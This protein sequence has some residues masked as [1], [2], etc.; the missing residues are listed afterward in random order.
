MIGTARV[1]LRATVMLG[2]G[3]GLG[4]TWTTK[5]VCSN[6]KNVMGMRFESQNICL[7]LPE[8]DELFEYWD[9]LLQ[10]PG[11]KGDL[12][13][14]PSITLSPLRFGDLQIVLPIRVGLGL[15]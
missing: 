5:F 14:F 12:Q 11:V 2:P 13:S 7:L 1:R 9:I 15:H 8:L 4:L 6:L 10:A 3:S